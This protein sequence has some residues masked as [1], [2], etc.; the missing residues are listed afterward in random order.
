MINNYVRKWAIYREQSFTFL[1]NSFETKY[2]HEMLAQVHVMK[3]NDQIEKEKEQRKRYSGYKFLGVY[4]CLTCCLLT[5]RKYEKNKV[6]LVV[7][8]LLV[9]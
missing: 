3:M 4:P 9:G 5:N 1:R 2:S 6:V 7:P 8:H